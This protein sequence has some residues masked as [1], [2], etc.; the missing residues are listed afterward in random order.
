MNICDVGVTAESIHIP[1]QAIERTLSMG[2][3]EVSRCEHTVSESIWIREPFTVQIQQDEN[4]EL[5]L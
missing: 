1:R 4:L 5:D 2:S 3:T